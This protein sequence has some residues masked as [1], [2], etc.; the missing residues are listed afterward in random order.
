MSIVNNKV[1][2]DRLK[3][4]KVDRPKEIKSRSN[5][6]NIMSIDFNKEKVDLLKKDKYRSTL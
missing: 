6:I 4:K 2:V 5:K 1:K 3:R